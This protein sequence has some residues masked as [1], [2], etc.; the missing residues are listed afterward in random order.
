MHFAARYETGH[1]L[2]VSVVVVIAIAV[3]TMIAI[4]V[5]RIIATT[6]IVTVITPII[7]PPLVVTTSMIMIVISTVPFAVIPVR[8]AA[9]QQDD[10]GNGHDQEYCAIHRNV[11]NVGGMEWLQL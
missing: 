11:L 4:I 10:A 6:I 1:K 8:A 5:T 2:N 9:S 3:A 7:V